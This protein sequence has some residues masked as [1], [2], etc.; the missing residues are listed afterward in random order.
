MYRV[1]GENVPSRGN[2]MGRGLEEPRDINKSQYQE[3]R[4]ELGRSGPGGHQAGLH[5]L[6]GNFDNDLGKILAPM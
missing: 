3:E 6:R 1:T 2:W 4:C 5:G